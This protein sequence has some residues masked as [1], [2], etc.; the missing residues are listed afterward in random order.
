VTERGIYF[1]KLF[2]VNPQLH[3]PVYTLGFFDFATRQTT[4]LA[5]L[6]QPSRIFQISGLSVSPDE[7][8]ILYGQRDKFDFDLMLV[9]NFR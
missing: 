2:L 7:Q 3:Q 1:L 4:E 5:T 6:E 9:E 8:S